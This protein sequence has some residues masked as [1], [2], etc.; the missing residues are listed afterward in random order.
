M[1]ERATLA[2]AFLLLVVFGTAHAANFSLTVKNDGRR[3]V[4]LG[5]FGYGGS[6]G[7]RM[8]FKIKDFFLHDIVQYATAGEK[9]GFSLD[10][11]KTA[12][13]ARQERNYAIKETKKDAGEDTEN[14]CFVDDSL[15]APRSR[16][17]IRLEQKLEEAHA[18]FTKSGKPESEMLAELRRSVAGLSTTIT[19]PESEPG[20]YALF[21][22][23][24]KK[25]NKNKD[26]DFVSFTVEVSQYN[27]EAITNVPSFLSYGERY[28][29]YMN[30]AFALMF[31]WGLWAWHQIV[32]RPAPEAAG[33]VRAIHKVMYFLAVV[34]IL[35]LLT[36]SAMLLHRQWTGQMS[37]GLDV[38]FYTVQ[39]IKGIVLFSVILLLGTGWSLLK[40]FL[41]ER[42][43]KILLLML[44][45]QIFVNIAL[46]MIEEQSEGSANWMWWRD[47]LRVLDVVC[48][49]AVLLPLVWSIKSVKDTTGGTDGLLSSSRRI[50]RLKQFRQFYIVAVA[51]IYATRILVPYADGI[52]PYQHT[53][54]SHFLYEAAAI[55]FYTYTGIMFQ[56]MALAGG[57]KGDDD[58]PEGVPV[59]VVAASQEQ[60]RAAQEQMQGADIEEIPL[61]DAKREGKPR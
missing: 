32:F 23:N 48:C 37:G 52:L 55:S 6:G 2:N 9:I 58:Q 21:F 60:Q 20:L 17:L 12:V 59:E 44:P 25:A 4:D 7:G 8:E 28:V 11:V 26:P 46:A 29:P 33:Q 54:L 34:K 30:F 42:D 3:V 56:P 5:V 53:W 41:S 45:L 15:V 50:S 47:S 10:L 1:M 38:V 61:D 18:A 49:C 57:G 40:P 22:Y 36:N 27:L 13:F 14:V 24:C 19:I 16:F 35:T 31:V 51:F 43:R 39:T